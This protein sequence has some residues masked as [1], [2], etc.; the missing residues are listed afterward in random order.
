MLLFLIR[1]PLPFPIC[2]QFRAATCESEEEEPKKPDPMPDSSSEE[3]GSDSGSDEEVIPVAPVK[4]VVV[5]SPKVGANSNQ[6]QPD[7]ARATAPA[8]A[9]IVP[10]LGKKRL[11]ESKADVKGSKKLKVVDTEIREWQRRRREACFESSE[12]KEEPVR[13]NSSTLFC[14]SELAT[15]LLVCQWPAKTLIKQLVLLVTTNQYSQMFGNDHINGER[16]NVGSPKK[17][18]SS[19]DSYSIEQ[20]GDTFES[21]RKVP[22]YTSQQRDDGFESDHNVPHDAFQPESP[23]CFLSKNPVRDV[24]KSLEKMKSLTKLSLS[25][26]QLQSLGSSLKSCS[27]LKELRLAHNELTA[28]PSELA[29]NARIHTLDLGNNS[30][31]N[32]SDLK[33][34]NS[35]TN[36]RNLNLHGN[37]IADKDKFVNKVKRLI[38]NLQILNSKPVDKYT[39]DKKVDAELS[40]VSF[41]SEV[42]KQE[43]EGEYAKDNKKPKHRK[44][45]DNEHG[46]EDTA[47]KKSKSKRQKTDNKQKQDELSEKKSKEARKVGDDVNDDTETPFSE[48]FAHDLKSLEDAGMK[49]LDNHKDAD[50]AIVK[51]TSKNKKPKSLASGSK[52]LEILAPSVDVGLGGPSTWE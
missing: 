51:L 6:K 25:H 50:Q 48:L 39:N 13:E 36:L 5:Q 40:A 44:D 33:V 23:C 19:H 52:T 38:P 37:P 11:G 42:G 17:C 20:S 9:M 26:C 14:L 43:K 27:E 1:S 31:I 41:A 7:S 34:L 8:S 16:A 30:I 24:G 4:P 3:D 18:T 2:L 12:V 21:D 15:M 28:L 46:D 45:L 29:H 35:L 47:E 22:H 32:W 10:K 49:L